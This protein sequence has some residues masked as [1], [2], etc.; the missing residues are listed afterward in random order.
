MLTTETIAELR[1]AEAIKAANVEL[2]T[3]PTTV[4]LPN[5]F[6]IHDIEKYLPERRRLRGEMTT[7]V[8]EHFAGYVKDNAEAGARVFIDPATMGAKAVLN[9]GTTEKPGHGDNVAT[10]ALRKT[11]G[12]LAFQAIATGKPLT[13][14]Q[15]AEFMEDW[16]GDL[17]CTNDSGELGMTKAIGLIRNI[18]VEGLRKLG[19]QEQQLS[20]TRSVLEQV[21]AKSEEPLPTH[22]FMTTIPMHGLSTRTF[23]MRLGIQTGGE[24]PAI[25]LRQVNPEKHA[26]E[27]AAE[28]ASLI[29]AAIDG[30]MPVILGSY[31]AK[32]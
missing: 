31:S 11:A 21:S 28:L 26:E 5:D 25:V 20:A 1:K 19:S 6:T 16:A 13:Q 15:V 30:S 23:A 29:T 7:T 32:A 17:Y 10:L 12:Y 24:K 8:I 14:T 2:T 27:M 4:A 9:I 18:T 22:F 3:A